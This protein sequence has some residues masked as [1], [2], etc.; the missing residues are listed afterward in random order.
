MN[1]YPLTAQIMRELAVYTG[2]SDPE[3]VF[4]RGFVTVAEFLDED[5]MGKPADDK[6]LGFC[7]TLD[8]LSDRVGK[9]W[10]CVFT[11]EKLFNALPLHRFASLGNVEIPVELE[12][13][14]DHIRARILRDE[15]ESHRI[16][17]ITEALRYAPG[18]TFAM[19]VIESSAQPEIRLPPPVDSD[20]AEKIMRRGVGYRI[21]WWIR[22]PT[23]ED[24]SG[25]RIHSAGPGFP[26]YNL[27]EIAPGIII[28]GCWP[29][30]RP[31][32]GTRSRKSTKVF[33]DANRY[34]TELS[35][36]INGVYTFGLDQQWDEGQPL[37]GTK[38]E[39][40]I[41]QLL[42]RIDGEPIAWNRPWHLI[43]RKRFAWTEPQSKDA[44]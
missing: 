28:A 2:N 36:L 30:G 13:V 8:F 6:Q 7:L 11:H 37:E 31:A 10:Q 24:E 34:R 18:R 22:D 9:F 23:P 5:F 27:A 29:T 4:V 19:P 26:Y 21:E 20:F 14:G 35:E 33:V 38:I 1:R 3:R 40:W 39:S 32:D 17:Y 16:K 25:M 41:Y 15:D 43:L 12:L 42:E 44:W